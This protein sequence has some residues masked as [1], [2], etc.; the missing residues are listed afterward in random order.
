MSNSH[1]Y[2]RYTGDY[3]KKTRHL[4]LSEHGAYALLLDHYY[5]TGS[6]PSN[7]DQVM[8][9]CSAFDEQEKRAVMNI[10]KQFFKLDG[11]RYVNDKVEEE[12]SKR[13]EISEKRKMAV[14]EREKKKR[15]N[16]TSCDASHDDTTTTT[17]IDTDVSIYS[18][19]K[20]VKI[21]PDSFLMPDGTFVDFEGFFERLWKL[22]PSQRAKGHKTQA[23]EILKNQLKEGTNYEEIGRGVARFRKYCDATGEL[24][25]DFFR[26]LK[27]KKWQSDYEIHSAGNTKLGTGQKATH[28]DA[29]RMA[30]EDQTWR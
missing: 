20:K 1:W 12:L 29:L 21:L 25:P 10:I 5:S 13:L 24:N 16:D 7:D 3:A 22:Y 18:L 4:S 23:K 28:E 15:S 8:R 6:L 27:G 17:Y 2:P 19:S 9:I 14:Q 11:D 26:W 30:L